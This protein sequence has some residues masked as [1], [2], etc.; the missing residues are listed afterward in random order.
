MN[1]EKEIFGLFGS[2]GFAREVMAVLA[3]HLERTRGSSAERAN[4]E[5]Y[6][7]DKS[8]QREINQIP[9]LSE[10]DFFALEGA[11]FFNIAIGDSRLREQVALNAEKMATPLSIL[12]NSA[13]IMDGNDIHDSAIL[14]AH[15]IVTSNAK[16]GRYF[17][18]NLY[19]YVAHDCIIGDFVTFAPKVC[20]NGNVV[21]KNHVSIGTGAIIRQGTPEKPLVVGERAVVGM[22]AV[23]TKDVPEDTTVIGNPARPLESS[24]V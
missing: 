24:R 4:R 15:S 16:I 17:H 7:V 3:E 14:C 6:F 2:G 20:C 8:G 11:K 19:S 10:D 22:G 21:I 12:S 5:L 1:S 13:Q 9:C 18:C 23:V